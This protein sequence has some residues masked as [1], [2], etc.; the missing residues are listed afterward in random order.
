MCAIL[1]HMR[2]VPVCGF[3]AAALL[4]ASDAYP[5]PRFTD[6]ERLRKL[7]SAL[8]EVDQIF[9]RYAA[10]KKIP[11][12]VWGIVIDGRLA[13]VE[14]AGVRDRASA[15]WSICSNSSAMPS[16]PA[17]EAEMRGILHGFHE[18][19]HAP[20]LDALVTALDL[21]YVETTWSSFRPTLPPSTKSVVHHWWDL[22][23]ADYHVDWA[24]PSA[25]TLTG[26]TKITVSRYHYLCDGQLTNCVP[27]MGSSTKLDAQGD[28]LMQRLVYRNFGDHHLLTVSDLICA[29]KNLRLRAGQYRGRCAAAKLERARQRQ[30]TGRMASRSRTSVSWWSWGMRR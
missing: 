23:W 28:K 30:R 18:P 29:D 6:V 8:P 14:S 17:R 20:I 12:M 5:P 16:L 7:E 21:R 3:F 11:G 26:P 22:N 19:M 25:S 2:F 13:H 4:L 10:D 15:A 24:T 27:Q 1:P 9:R